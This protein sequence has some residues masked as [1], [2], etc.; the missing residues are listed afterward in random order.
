M[1]IAE[2]AAKIT[3]KDV[4]RLHELKDLAHELGNTVQELLGK[5]RE[6]EHSYL[7][8]VEKMLEKGARYCLDVTTP[9]KEMRSEI[10][11]LRAQMEQRKYER[12]LLVVE[13]A[14]EA[15]QTA[16]QELRMRGMLAGTLDS[17]PE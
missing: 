7:P 9:I 3:A 13:A 17:C 2:Y 12:E 4:A 5:C 10:Y 8:R 14:I 11:V 15:V 1:V 16:M 6:F